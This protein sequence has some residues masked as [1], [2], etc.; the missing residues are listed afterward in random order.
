M[1]IYMLFHYFLAPQIP[2][3]TL[4]THPSLSRKIKKTLYFHLFRQLSGSWSRLAA[5][6]FH[7][8]RGP[9][10]HENIVTYMFVPYFLA[11]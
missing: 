9:N 6:V 5:Y 10:L 7:G 4:L 3:K 1:V 2:L 11:P 8:L